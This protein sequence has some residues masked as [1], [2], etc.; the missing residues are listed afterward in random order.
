MD[1]LRSLWPN[2]S[3]NV[4]TIPQHIEGEMEDDLDLKVKALTYLFK[5]LDIESIAPFINDEN[6][7][8]NFQGDST[9]SNEKLDTIYNKA[10][11]ERLLLSDEHRILV[12]WFKNRFRSLCILS[13]HPKSPFE[14]SLGKGF[15]FIVLSADSE[16]EEYMTTLIN[17]QIYIEHSVDNNVKRQ[18]LKDI[19]KSQRLLRPSYKQGFNKNDRTNIILQYVRKLSETVQIERIY[20]ASLITKLENCKMMKLGKI[21]E[22]ADKPATDD[23]EENGIRL[24]PGNTL[25]S[26][27]RS[28]VRRP[29][30]E[31]SPK[32]QVRALSPVK[33]N[34]QLQPSFKLETPPSP[35]KSSLTGPARLRSRSS[36]P[37]KSLKKKQSMTLLKMDKSL[38]QQDDNI[39]ED[40]WITRADMALLK[41]QAEQ[42]VLTRVDRE[43]KLVR[44]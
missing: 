30:I 17:S 12:D 28:P 27:S 16:D 4:I 2:T 43:R 7:M 24:F 36:S 37:L 25:R 41:T 44:G 15:H 22:I 38:S 8:Y 42:A 18:I 3:S 32:P 31:S 5:R 9:I 34:S 26:G 11:F 29:S 33:L 35:A 23:I 10:E 1:F 6:G 40:E 13:N 14:K 39:S 19:L 20:K 21:N